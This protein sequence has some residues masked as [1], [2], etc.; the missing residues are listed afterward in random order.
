VMSQPTLA[1][2]TCIACGWS[3]HHG[4][5]RFCGNCGRS[6]LA[7]EREAVTVPAAPAQLASPVERMPWQA[8]SVLPKEGPRR[9]A[10]SKAAI[11]TGVLVAL[12]LFM[13]F[14]Q[15]CDKQAALDHEAKCSEEYAQSHAYGGSVSGE[16][17]GWRPD[18]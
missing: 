6:L 10:S 17:F 13:L 14:I 3:P 12:V 11:V 16:C 5:H 2:V 15:A 8:A 9:P 1:P 7:V 4:P 18:R